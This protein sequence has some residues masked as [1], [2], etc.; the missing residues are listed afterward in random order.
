MLADGLV[1]LRIEAVEPPEIRCKVLLGGSLS[2]HKG[3]AVPRGAKGINAFTE[4]DR[5]L[6]LEG[7][8]MGVEMAALSFVR[9]REDVLRARRL[10]DDRGS[11]L[12]LMAKIEKP[13]DTMYTLRIGSEDP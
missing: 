4:K 8:D 13:V 5:E 9:N 6:L 7:L 11:G 12:L 10:L 2:D 3:I 1:E